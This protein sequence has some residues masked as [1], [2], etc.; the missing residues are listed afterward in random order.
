VSG[1]QKILQAYWESSS[2]GLVVLARDWVS[3]K[4][5]PPLFF[6]PPLR[7]FENLQRTSALLYGQMAGYLRFRGK[8]LFTYEIPERERSELAEKG[9]YVA[10]PFN[11][12]KPLDHGTRWRLQRTRLKGIEFA[13]LPVES[14]EID[15]K[16]KFPFKF[17]KGDGA[18]LDVSR[19][20]PN[21]VFDDTG[22]C[23]FEF[24]PERTGL[25]LYSFSVSEDY[26]TDGQE[27]IIWASGEGEEIRHL[28]PTKAFLELESDLKMGAVPTER[29]T[30]F[31]LFA[32]RAEK[33]VLEVSSDPAMTNLR[34][35][36][37]DE[38]ENGVWSVVIP[39][40][41]ERWFYQYRVFGTSPDASSQFN[42][43]VPIL[44]PYAKASFSNAG[45]G[46]IL[47]KSFFPEG[48]INSGFIPPA[49]DDLVICECHVRDLIAKVPVAMKDQDRL[50]F[51][52]LAKWIRSG[53]S[54]LHEL[55]V[56]TIE[57][58]PIQEFDSQSKDEYHWGYM[59]VNYFSPESTYALNPAKATQVAEFRDLVRA[60]HEQEFTV[61][62]DV[63]YNHIGEPNNLLFLDKYYYFHLDTH[64]YLMNWSGCGNDVRTD[65]PM[66][67]RI[68]IES[69][70]HLVEQYG[71]DGFRFDL[72][73]LV[74]KPTLQAIEKELK[75]RYPH[76]VLISEP[77][78]FRGHLADELKDTGWASWNDGYR[79]FLA[80]YVRGQSNQDAA[81]YF[82][83]GSPHSR[84]EWPAQTVNYSESH[85]DYCWLDRIT[86]NPGHDAWNPTPADRRRTHL[87]VAFLFSSLGIPM[88][89][90]G[91][92]ALRTKRGIHNT[93]QRGDLNAIDYERRCYYSGTANYFAQWVRLRLSPTGHLLRP[94]R[95]RDGYLSFSVQ[96]GLSAIACVFNADGQDGDAKLLFAINP[97]AEPATLPVPEGA[98]K[99]RWIQIADH[100]RVARG[101]LEGALH[102]ISEDQIHLPA[103]SCG[104]WKS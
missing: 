9:I 73:D 16:Q 98:Q 60:M 34:A 49:W 50:G 22:S 82:L 27:Q 38:P 89:S 72:A 51:T 24:H 93:Y 55:G 80:E 1:E 18:W 8:T 96:D 28:P 81:R 14:N 54:Y 31:R 59:P 33:V 40:N 42:P 23:N 90:A 101:G 77:W 65:A 74:G 43:N 32:P 102:R 103:M 39:E 63:V 83:A 25:H 3:R 64:H 71:V 87:M 91:Q 19:S 46:I 11:D 94:G 30:T 58:Q 92:D 52:G 104:L 47:G 75:S 35:F 29:K 85:D 48:G 100:E 69:L 79:D 68:I 99:I 57:L 17:Q 97:H 84:T 10:G 86:E 95:H 12:W 56:N 36:D 70:I 6:G 44:D 41:L 13:A 45:P 26:E 53:R 67:R 37:L 76:L 4:E 88:I 21:A 15:S 78:S 20:A 7:P 66:V 61:I 62:L 5:K 2:T